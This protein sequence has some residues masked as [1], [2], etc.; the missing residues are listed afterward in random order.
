MYILKQNKSNLAQY[1]KNLHQN[2]LQIC[3]Y[4]K[5]YDYI[6]NRY[7]VNIS[8]TPLCINSTFLLLFIPRSYFKCCR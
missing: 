7:L 3:L 2:H 5:L 6:Q 4:L 8:M 1:C